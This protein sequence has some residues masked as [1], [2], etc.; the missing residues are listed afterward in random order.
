MKS[1][2][3]RMTSIT[4]AE[5]HSDTFFE[6]STFKELSED[7]IKTMKIYAVEISQSDDKK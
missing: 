7:Q 1:V 5:G 2:P 4:V 3:Q 6:G